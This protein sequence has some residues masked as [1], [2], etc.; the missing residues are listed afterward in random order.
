MHS[1]IRNELE[2]H[3]TGEASPTFY[4]HLNTCPECLEEVSAMADASA[5]LRAL[6]PDGAE[7]EALPGFYNRVVSEIVDRRGAETWSLFS[8]GAAFFRRVAFASLLTLAVLGT[9]LV[10]RE[11]TEGGADAAAIMAEHKN[12]DGILLTLASYRP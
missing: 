4:A 8:P 1:V 12:A 11:S 3:L 2:S 7:P 10:T 9:V 6:K 5:V